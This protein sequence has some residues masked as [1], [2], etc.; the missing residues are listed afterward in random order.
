[1]YVQCNLEC[2]KREKHTIITWNLDAVHDLHGNR[3]SHHTSVYERANAWASNVSNDVYCQNIARQT[4]TAIA[5]VAMARH[6]FAF[7]RV[8]TK[9]HS[10]RVCVRMC[11]FLIMCI[12]TVRLLSFILVFYLLLRFWRWRTVFF[13][14]QLWCAEH[15]HHCIK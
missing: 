4:G 12:R 5:F 8:T 15:Q 10:A 6:M 14:A 2:E 7:V 1:M 3:S 9:G 11:R 13:G